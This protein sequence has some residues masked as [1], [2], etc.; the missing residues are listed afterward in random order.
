M[1]VALMATVALKEQFSGRLEI[2]SYLDVR[3]V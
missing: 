1:R 2:V 3:G